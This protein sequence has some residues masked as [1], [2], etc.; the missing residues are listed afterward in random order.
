MQFPHILQLALGFKP[1]FVGVYVVC[2]F[3]K[4]KDD[5]YLE[6]LIKGGKRLKKEVRGGRE[7][8][9]EKAERERER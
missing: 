5:F 8:V 6:V 2:S 7:R 9:R 3:F 4:V 1:C